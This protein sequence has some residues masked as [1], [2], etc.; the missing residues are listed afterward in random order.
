MQGG[1][2]TYK[3]MFMVVFWRISKDKSYGLCWRCKAKP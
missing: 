3:G 1:F 2:Q